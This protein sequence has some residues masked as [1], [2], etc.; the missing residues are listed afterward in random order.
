M[1]EPCG[2]SRWRSS[3]SRGALAAVLIAAVGCKPGVPRQATPATQQAAQ[4]PSAATQPAAVT[5][6]P[7]AGEPSS[8][9][10]SQPATKP[11]TRPASTYIS[12]PPYPVNLYVLSPEEQQPG[13]LTIVQL[14]DDKTPATCTGLFP[15][16]NEINVDTANVRELRLHIGY[17]PLGERKRIVLH[18]DGQAIELARKH[19]SFVVLKRSETGRWDP[20][21]SED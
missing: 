12:K 2:Y 3:V 11:A 6:A 14:F 13:W 7:A 18:I 8:K 10:A 21:R 16:Q 5:T 20:L 17:L 1:Q 15:E 9:P 4:E 19:R